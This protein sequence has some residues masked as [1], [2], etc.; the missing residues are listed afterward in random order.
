MK[1]LIKAFVKFAFGLIL[2]GTLLFFPAGTLNYINGWLFMGLL[3]VPMLVLGVF[4]FVKAPKLLEKRLNSR[5]GD[6]TQK[7]VVAASGIMFIAG[8]TVA[9]LDYRFSWSEVPL[10]AVIIAAVILL[11]SYVFLF[12]HKFANQIAML[13]R[14]GHTCAVYKTSLCIKKLCVFAESFLIFCKQCFKLF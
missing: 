8:F 10:W 14:V 1:L 12:Y 3:F 5:E 4:L 6:K 7:G 9:G 11:V 13:N 2:V